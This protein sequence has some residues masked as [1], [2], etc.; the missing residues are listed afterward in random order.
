MFGI[1]V[2]EQMFGLRNMEAIMKVV[3]VN[4]HYLNRRHYQRIF[5]RIIIFITILLLGLSITHLASKAETIDE[6]H[7]Y[8]YY[9][10][11]TVQSGDTLYSIAKANLT[12]YD[13]VDTYIAEVASIN[14]LTSADIDYGMNLIIP[15]YSTTFVQ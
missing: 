14:H 8:K 13:S 7:Y 1:M 10:S 11:I 2:L 6:L 3:K 4:G 12:N 5:R 15:Y 9:T